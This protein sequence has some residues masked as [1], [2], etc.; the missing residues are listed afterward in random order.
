MKS[1]FSRICW[2]VALTL[3]VSLSVDAPVQADIYRYVDKN[4][5]WHFTNIKTDS[6]YRIF[7]P[8]S[9]KALGKYLDDYRGIIE[10][11]SA[12]FGIE[13]HFIRAVIKAESGFDHRAVSSKGAQ[14][15]M[16][17]MPG[18]AGDMEVSDPFD[19]EDNI[20]GGVRYLSLLLK[21]FK[22]NKILALAA[23]N[24]GPNTVESYN[25]VPPFRET[26]EFVNRVMRYYETYQPNT[27]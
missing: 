12:Q 18:T 17:L 8:S 21:R 26:R 16:Q 10:Q 15:L 5:V 24:A 11:A 7:V 23:Y 9:R 3:A 2:A 4:G 25:G 1:F 13:P 20:F 27:K 14:G 6:R 22:N 19:P